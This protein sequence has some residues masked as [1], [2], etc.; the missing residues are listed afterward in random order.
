MGMPLFIYGTAWKEGATAELVKTAVTAGF[1]AIDTAN[2]PQHY[3]EALVGEALATLAKQG[4]TRENLFLQTKF[5]PV[6][7]QDHRIPYD[8]SADLHTQVWQSFN[9][10]LKNLHTDTVDSYLLHGPYS[11]PGLSEEDW[12]VWATL[13]EIYK[14]GKAK[15]IGISNVNR[16][17]VELL[18][19]KAKVKPMVVQNR[20]FAK[21]GWDRDVR[22]FC[23]ANNIVYQGFSLLTANPFVLQ[24]SQVKKIASRVGKNP[25]QVV[26]RFAVQAG[27]TPLTGTTDPQHMKDDLQIFDFELT[28]D[29]V[30]LIETIAG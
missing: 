28:K 11:H 9:S 20:C 7:G 16:G 17:Q 4:M 18:F 1:K 29:E 30:N 24:D 19:E 5:T 15:A 2:Q 21:M 22:D 3:Q 23:K 13:E 6:D 12:E 14:S 8:P 25:I 27:M 10:S 26:F